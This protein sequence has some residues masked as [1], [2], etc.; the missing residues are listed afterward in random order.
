VTVCI[1]RRESI[2]REWLVDRNY[3]SS[4][5]KCWYM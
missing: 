5:M 4:I 2:N 3:N 1:S